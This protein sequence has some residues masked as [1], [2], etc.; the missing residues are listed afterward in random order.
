MKRTFPRELI[1]I[2]RLCLT[3]PIG[4]YV[5]TGKIDNINFLLWSINFIYFARSV[6]LLN[7]EL[8]LQLKVI[9]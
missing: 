9:N 6:F 2:A 8:E 1:G 7:C 4:Y 5:G 3:A